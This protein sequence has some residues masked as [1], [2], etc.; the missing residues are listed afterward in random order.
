MALHWI[1]CTGLLISV[2]HIHVDGLT[3]RTEPLHSGHVLSST[4]L[5][6]NH[7]V[8]ELNN[9]RVVKAWT[10]ISD[11]TGKEELVFLANDLEDGTGFGRYRDRVN[12]VGSKADLNISRL[13]VADTGDYKCEIDYYVEGL[14]GEGKTRLKVYE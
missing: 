14:S 12:I 2:L 4:I 1:W 8:P 11:Q 9:R 6:C 3:V 10:M 7:D 5:K 13:E